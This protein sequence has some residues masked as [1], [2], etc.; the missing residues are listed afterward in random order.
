M[1]IFCFPF[2]KTK[3]NNTLTTLR[4]LLLILWKIKYFNFFY[5]VKNNNNNKLTKNKK[6]NDLK[7]KS[8]LFSIKI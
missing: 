3:D 6:P 2:L 1:H 8:K 4:Q 7:P 5:L